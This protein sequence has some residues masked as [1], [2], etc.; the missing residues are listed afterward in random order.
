MEKYQIFV[1]SVSYELKET[2]SR[3]I[4]RLLKNM[5]Y[6]PVAM[7]HFVS[8]DN[9]LEMLWDYLKQ[10]DVVVLILKNSYGSPIGKTGEGKLAE[11]IGDHP[12]IGDSLK[13]MCDGLKVTPDQLTF[14]QI[15]YVFS[16]ALKLP[17]LSFVYREN[18]DDT[19]DGSK[20][21]NFVGPGSSHCAAGWTEDEE[22][23]ELIV[24]SL[25]AQI[26]NLSP[27][28]GWVRKSESLLYTRTAKA[29][30]CDLSLDGKGFVSV[31]KSRM[32]E[33]KEISMF[34][35]TGR[36][37]IVTNQDVFADFIA[38]GGS[39]RLIC[40]LPCSDFLNEVAGVERV[41]Y[42]KRDD[43]HDEFEEV[44]RTMVHIYS[45]ALYLHGERKLSGPMGHL[46]IGGSN[47]LFRASV[48][49]A[50]T[51]DEAYWGWLTVTL[52]PEKSADMISLQLEKTPDTINDGP[53]NLLKSVRDHIECVW[54]MAA[55]N[56]LTAEI[57]DRTDLV[58]I[59]K[60]FTVVKEAALSNREYWEEKHQKALTRSKQ[61]A[62]VKKVL[63]EIAAQHPLKDGEFPDTE[64]AARL[65]RGIEIYEKRK[66]AGF[67][68]EI[69]VPGSVHLDPDG[70]PD[71]CSL[72][73]AGLNYLKEKGIPED[74]LHG[75]DLVL[76]YASLRELPGCY[77]TGDECD[78]ASRYFLE[79][80]NKFGTLISVCSPNQVMRKTLFY[81]D[82]EILPQVVSVPVDRMFHNFI[83]EIY[84]SV[85]NI[86][87]DDHDY[88]GKDSK[89]GI[90][91]RKERME[92]FEG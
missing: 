63:I 45:R 51:F 54:N 73:E 18:P 67:E 37:I 60:N 56:K 48:L 8:F 23:A 64:F 13:M 91:T 84:D 2:R 6:F 17:L 46:Y 57:T 20:L 65:D 31:L 86:L 15:E 30:I 79:P 11:M 19:V 34:F 40:G 39:I 55:D 41:K 61:N 9:T 43:I 28:S 4:S 80:Q 42:G 38:G 12:E 71:L 10:T 14:T 29:G 32:R 90:R 88:Q 74:I 33:F 77:N 81:L 89:E 83:H 24:N 47:T 52:P 76:R 49:C 87:M 66:K 5:R 53:D 16:R 7:E 75:D 69:Y 1:S 72:S 50:K 62:R 21:Q 85:P 27:V 70:I 92:G 3:V 68:V 36:G 58:E 35:T 78:L 25:D 59:L 82:H 44:L 26:M 22:L